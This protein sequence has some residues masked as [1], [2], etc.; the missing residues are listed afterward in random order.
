MQKWNQLPSWSL[1]GT[2]KPQHENLLNIFN[3]CLLSKPGLSKDPKGSRFMDTRDHRGGLGPPGGSILGSGFHSRRP[4][5]A[6]SR[7]HVRLCPA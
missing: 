7:E 2:Y 1:A 5:L 4:G 6:D 3:I